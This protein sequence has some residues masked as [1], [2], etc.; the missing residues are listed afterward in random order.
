MKFV[1]Q[2]FQETCFRLH[3]QKMYINIF[4]NR[5]LVCKIVKG[6]RYSKKLNEKQITALLEVSCQ[7]PHSSL[8][9]EL[10]LDVLEDNLF[11][12]IPF[13]F[14]SFSFRILTVRRNAYHEDPYAEEFGIKIC[15]KFASVE[16][17]VLRAHRLKYHDTGRESLLAKSWPVEYDE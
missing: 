10:W 11:L 16:A 8:F 2:Y 6:Q 1:V 17:R 4:F 9:L 7:H 14:S 3:V 5:L 15:D 13:C 12:H